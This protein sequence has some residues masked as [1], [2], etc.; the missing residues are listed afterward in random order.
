MFPR[1]VDIGAAEVAVSSRLLVDWAAQVKHLDDAS[2]TQVKVAADDLLN[3][4]LCD[5]VGAKGIDHDGYR[6]SDA[7]GVGQ[8]HLALVGQACSDDVLCN[9]AGRIGCTA[10]NLRGVFAREGTAM[11]GPAAIGVDDN[12]AA[13]EARV[14]LRAA[15]DELARGVDEDFCIVLEELSRNHR[16]DDLLDEILA[17]LLQRHVLIVL[18]RD[19]DGLDSYCLAILIGNRDLGLAIRTEIRQ[20]TV[21]ADFRQAAGQTMSQR[22]RQR[23]ELR[24]LV[25]RIAEHHALVASTDSLSGVHLA[26]AGL[27][28]LVHALG[29]IRRLLIEG[30]EDAAGIGIEAIFCPRIANFLDRITDN[31]R[32]IDIALRRN[33]ADDMYLSRRYHRLAGNTAH[34]VLGQDG[35]E[36]AVGNL[37]CHL[38]RMTFSNRLRSKKHTFLT[39]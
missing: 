12:L 36:D 30:Y 13:R 20:R 3:L 5:L 23:H 38:I 4:L 39:H 10:V 8:L 18:G 17:D 25:R 28:S 24:R 14:P 35:I 29:D 37:V 27:D 26:L 19:D 15:D 6:I 34:G 22:D 32:D 31:P 11:T 7:D 16:F 21:L 9:I 1:Q 33:L 2:R